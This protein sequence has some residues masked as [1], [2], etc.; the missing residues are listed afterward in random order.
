MGYYSWHIELENFMLDGIMAFSSHISV[1]NKA[2]LLNCVRL[3]KCNGSF[4]QIHKYNSENVL[5]KPKQFRG[6]YRVCLLLL[7]LESCGRHVIPLFL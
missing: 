1:C 6:I 2:Y 7:N 5:I 3:F 4:L